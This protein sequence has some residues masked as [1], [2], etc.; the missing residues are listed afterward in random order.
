MADADEALST[1]GFVFAVGL[2]LFGV[3]WLLG[4][5]GVRLSG[6]PE[7]LVAVLWLLIPPVLLL[8]RYHR[9]GRTVP[10]VSRLLS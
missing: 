7:V 5:L 4:L 9:K 1:L 3:P 2:W 10:V 8:V 6:W